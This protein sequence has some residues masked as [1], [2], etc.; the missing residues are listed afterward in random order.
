MIQ[1]P[2]ILL[3]ILPLGTDAILKIVSKEFNNNRTII[4]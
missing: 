1:N 4:S 2:E 3:K